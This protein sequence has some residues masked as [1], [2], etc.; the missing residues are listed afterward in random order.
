MTWLRKRIHPYCWG[1]SD[2]HKEDF[3]QTTKGQVLRT[4]RALRLGLPRGHLPKMKNS[5]MMGHFVGMLILYFEADGRYDTPEVIICIDI[6]CHGKGSYEGACACVAWLIDNE[7]PGL[8]WSRS[9]NGRGVHAYLRVDKRGTNARALDR[10]LLAL[11]R[12][13]KYQL[14]IHRWDI[15]DIEVKG[16]PPIFSWGDERH[17]LLG[18]KMGSLAKLPVEAL[19]RPLELMNTTLREVSELRRL[20]DE[21]PGDRLRGEEEEEDNCTSRF[22]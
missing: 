14:K 21:V 15:E 9:T 12:W 20:G 10:A 6:D 8:F 22:A 1:Q 16:R 13:L 3:E 11:E 18:L 5:L 17:E 4:F 2:R 19:D 7:F